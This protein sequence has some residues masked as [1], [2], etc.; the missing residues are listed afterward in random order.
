VRKLVA[1]SDR[2]IGLQWKG[3]AVDTILET[4]RGWHWLLI[5]GRLILLI[6][7]IT[8]ELVAVKIFKMGA[9]DQEAKLAGGKL[10]TY[11]TL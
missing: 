3:K 11:P 4:Y 5:E 8:G 6:A 10:R 2:F 9:E 7:F 1:G